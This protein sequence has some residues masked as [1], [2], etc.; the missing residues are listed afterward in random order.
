MNTRTLWIDH[1]EALDAWVIHAKS[2]S[3]LGVDTEFE[4]VRTFFPRL[5]LLQMATSEQAVCID[6]LAE[7]DWDGVRAL[8]SEPQ[9]VKIFHAARQDLEVLQQHFSVVPGAFFDTQIAA[10]FCGY[11]EQ[12]GYARMVKEI[13]DVSLSKAF[14]RT[15]W[16]RRPLSEAEV[17]YALDD[18]HYLGTLYHTLLAVMFRGGFQAAYLYCVAHHKP[19]PRRLHCPRLHIRKSSPP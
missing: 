6:P 14:T 7:L 10:A 17:Q 4:R 3:W 16:C 18:V 2:A 15:P 13:C 12:V 5:C 9:P 1:Q 19:R 11:G 8:I